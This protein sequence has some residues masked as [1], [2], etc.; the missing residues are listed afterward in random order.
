MLF[1]TLGF[2][3]NLSW[4]QY[5][6]ADAVIGIEQYSFSISPGFWRAD[7]DKP[8]LPRVSYNDFSDNVRRMVS[9]NAPWQ[10]ITTFN[11]LEKGVWWRH[12]LIGEVTQSMEDTLTASTS[13]IDELLIYFARACILGDHAVAG[14]R[15]YFSYFS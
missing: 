15:V 7:K 12:R 3:L 9:S 8:F 13:G 6:P 14:L 2:I 1:L 10:L 4:H 11:E 5:G